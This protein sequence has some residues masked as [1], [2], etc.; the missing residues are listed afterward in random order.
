M[1]PVLKGSGTGTVP[2]LSAHA[3]PCETAMPSHQRA[4]FPL[5]LLLAFLVIASLLA[6]HPLYPRDWA[7]ENLIVLVTLPVLGYG[8][9]HLRFS[10]VSYFALFVLYVVHEVGAH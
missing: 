3:M 10:N 7:L 4:S 6:I 9:H 1:R 5:F 8:Y 2:G